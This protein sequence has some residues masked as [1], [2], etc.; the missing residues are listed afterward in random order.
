MPKKSAARRDAAAIVSSEAF[1][2]TV[3]DPT[4]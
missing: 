2:C 1:D 4:R 3:D